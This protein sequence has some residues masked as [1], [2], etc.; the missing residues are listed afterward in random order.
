MALFAC[1]SCASTTN[2]A[3]P[4]ADERPPNV[5]VIFADDQGYAE[6][7][8]YGLTDIPTPSID[9]LAEKG[10]RFT[11]GY[12]SAPACSPSRAGLL[13]GRYQQRF[14]HEFNPGPSREAGLPLSQVTMADHF[15]DAGYKTGL[16]GK[17]HLGMSDELH[18]MNRGF[19]EF[20]GFL[21]GA[22]HYLEPAQNASKVDLIQRGREPVSEKAYLTDAFGRE[23]ADFIQR[24]GENPWF[25]FLSF[26]AVH[27]PLQATKTDLARFAHIS[28][29]DRRTYAGMLFAMDRAIGLALEELERQGLSN[30]TLIF[31]LS[32]N[33][34]PTPSTTSSNAPLR[35]KKLEMYEGGIRIPF[36]ARWDGHIPAGEVIGYP[37]SALDILPTSLAAAGIT[38]ERGDKFDGVDLLPFLQGGPEV[39]HEALFWRMGGESAMRWGSY[40]LVNHRGTVELYDLASDLA[41]TN[42]ISEENPEVIAEM[43]ALYRAWDVTM[44][45]PLWLVH[46]VPN[47]KSGKPRLARRFSL[48]DRDGDEKLSR[49]EL[50][51]FPTVM[52]A[53][54]N[55]DD[56]VTL[57]EAEAW[58]VLFP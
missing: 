30:D 42:D 2:E 9:S 5:L 6:A 53:D 10:V 28:D 40:K 43:D 24:Q 58:A 47:Q 23:A 22:H 36:I 17:W 45:S 11:D 7:G 41:E 48:L 39:P 52:A 32:D 4:G 35:G 55:G 13:T 26:N 50:R 57:E 27:I 19:D 46:G 21:W 8:C 25:L 38:P 49:Q 44:V 16:V 29:P 3:P 37:V 18:P 15:Q 31:F 12:V 14:G 20:F 34:G 56:F 33:G 54:T 51:N 1:G